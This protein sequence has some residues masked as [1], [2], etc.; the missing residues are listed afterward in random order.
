MT[1]VFIATDQHGNTHNLY[2]TVEGHGA[3]GFGAAGVT[4]GVQDLRARAIDGFPVTIIAK[5]VYQYTDAM[6]HEYQLTCDDP[7]A[8]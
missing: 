6:G 7:L 2:H 8:P 4:T 3:S 1:T 5:G